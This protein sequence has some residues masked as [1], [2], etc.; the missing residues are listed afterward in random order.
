MT[1]WIVLNRTKTWT[2]KVKNAAYCAHGLK[3][4]IQIAFSFVIIFSNCFPSFQDFADI[5]AEPSLEQPIIIEDDEDDVE[6]AESSESSGFLLASCQN[7]VVQ[8]HQRLCLSYAQSLWYEPSPLTNQSKDHISALV[9]SYQITAPLIA[10]FYH[11]MGKCI[12]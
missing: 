3:V 10:R 2:I 7:T 11:L 4:S 5:T 8:V 12:I 6:E 9:S 1:Q